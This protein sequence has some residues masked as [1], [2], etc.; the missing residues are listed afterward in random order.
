[1]IISTPSESLTCRQI[2]NQ[3]NRSINKL[4]ADDHCDKIVRTFVTLRKVGFRK[5]TTMFVVFD[6]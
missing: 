3:I 1:M 5:V 6:V 2:M 4:L